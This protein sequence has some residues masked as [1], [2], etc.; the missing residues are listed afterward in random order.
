[1]IKV[2]KNKQTEKPGKALTHSSMGKRTSK[3]IVEI[4]SVILYCWA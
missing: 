2:E 3:D 4:I 1:M